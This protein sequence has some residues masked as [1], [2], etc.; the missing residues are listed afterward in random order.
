MRGKPTAPVDRKVGLF[1][2]VAVAFSLF[3]TTFGYS[4]ILLWYT[5]RGFTAEIRS[6]ADVA[7]ATSRGALA[8]RDAR[9]G[10][11][12]LAA[13]SI[14]DEIVF[15]ALYHPD[16]QIF[17]QHPGNFDR[18]GHPL[19]NSSTE[20]E[21]RWSWSSVETSVPVELDG[22]VVGSLYLVASLRRVYEQLIIFASMAVFLLLVA[23]VGAVYFQRKLRKFV[24]EPIML[25]RDKALEVSMTK[26]FSTRLGN[27]TGGVREVHELITSF[28]LMLQQLE[29]RDR[30][31]ILAKDRAEEADR[32]KSVFLAT[33]SH[34]L[35]TPLHAILGMTE[36]VLFSNVNDD[37]KELLEIVL[38]SGSLLISIIND[39]LDFTK[40]EAG[41]FS[42]FPVETDLPDLLR[43]TLRLF[44]LDAQKKGLALEL[45]IASTV[46][47]NLLIDE[48]RLTQI[49]VNLV[50]NALKFTSRGHIIVRVERWTQAKPDGSA[51]V[52]LLFTVADTGIGVP[53]DCLGTIFE[54]FSQLSRGAK[55]ESGTGLGLAIASRLV[56][57]M[58]G[59][60]WAE[61]KVGE[62][63]TIHFIV[64]VGE[65]GTA[66]TQ[67]ESA[68]M[69]AE[70]AKVISASR[71]ALMSGKILVVEDNPIN[72]K[73]AHRVLSRAGYDVQVV[74]NGQECLNYVEQYSVDV[75]LMDLSMPV[76]DGLTATREIRK[77]EARTA[78]RRSVIIALTANAVDN[79]VS[80]CLAAGMDAYLTKPFDRATLL[81]TVAR[82]IADGRSGQPFA[83]GVESSTNN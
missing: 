14:K 71:P 82:F 16:G 19:P 12:V 32:L 5:K 21:S 59:R 28:N 58:D 2:Y 54:A 26:D 65:S 17:V 24:A 83:A 77:F 72:S 81:K 76:M 7:A 22:E 25:L 10:E 44:E 23:G 57:L 68:K 31:L 46:P 11:R 64:Y 53:E 30:A 61:S 56:G 40:I 70:R 20:T 42:L 75:I 45:E 36:Q 4:G 3:V 66:E 49:I 8:F 55:Y 27:P 15:A 29:E 48:A 73:L 35:R 47:P 69:P 33:V 63:T 60:I 80:T 1:F 34:E 13:L 43:R 74:V 6:I 78:C 67:E 37:Q 52:P 62:G 79:E 39:I 9:A 18:S 51:K 38:G 41:K 50:G